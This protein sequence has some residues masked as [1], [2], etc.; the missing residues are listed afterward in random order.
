VS[1][2]AEP[3]ELDAATVPAVEPG[4]IDLHDDAPEPMPVHR[5][6]PAVGAER[7]QALRGLREPVS[8]FSA[9]TALRVLGKCGVP[10]SPPPEQLYAARVERT[11]GLVKLTHVRIEDTAE[12]REREERRRAK[13]RPPRPTASWRNRKSSKLRRML[14][15]DLGD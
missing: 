12:W 7:L 11:H 13:Q 14:G 5:V 15:L 4:D 10:V 9:D 8:I 3:D 2:R 6:V 1:D